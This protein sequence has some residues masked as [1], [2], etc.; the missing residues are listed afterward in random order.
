MRQSVFTTASVMPQAPRWKSSGTRLAKRKSSMGLSAGQR[1]AVGQPDLHLER[2][3]AVDLGR[4]GDGG[5]EVVVPLDLLDA[6]L[7]RRVGHSGAAAFAAFS[8]F[9]AFF[10]VA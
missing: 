7:G 9:D 6:L 8:F 5:D 1:A 3:A 10:F 2:V 4:A